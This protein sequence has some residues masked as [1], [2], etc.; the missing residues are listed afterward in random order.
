MKA[1]CEIDLS[2]GGRIR[3]DKAPLRRQESGLAASFEWEDTFSSQS[4]QYRYL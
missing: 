1:R 3:P 4:L 2:P